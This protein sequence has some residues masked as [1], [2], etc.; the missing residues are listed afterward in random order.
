MAVQSWSPTAAEVFETLDDRDVLV[1]FPYDSYADSVV[2][3]L[4]QAA[5]DPA[6]LAI[7]QT[8]YRPVPDGP[9]VRA[10]R[11]AAERGAPVVAVVGLGGRLEDERDSLASVQALERAGAHVV[12]GVVGLRMHCP[13]SLVIRDGG[14]G[15]SRYAVVG[16]AL[17][18]P[19]LRP[20]GL[21]LLTAAPDV[22]ADLTDLFNHLTGFSRPPRFR[23]LLV[24]P[25]HLR[26]RILELIGREGAAGPAGRIALKVHQLVDPEIVDALDRASQQ[27]VAVNVLDGRDSDTS[28]VFAFG[29]GET[30]AV[31]L[32]SGDLA[33]GPVDSQIDVAV[34]I[35]DLVH[36]ARLRAMVGASARIHC[37]EGASL[38]G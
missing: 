20:E 5:A 28:R 38:A 25:E 36:Q 14:Q 7:K 15:L 10:L 31:Y 26:S 19:T 3:L 6:L 21:S 33:P 4:D 16:T 12:Y 13:L 32:S 27:G 22:T 24:G 23:T 2:A 29:S 34:P 1:H 30:S 9:T 37:G 8:L 35:R 11:R 18:H 17:H